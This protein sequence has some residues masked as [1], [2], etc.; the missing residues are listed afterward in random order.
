[1]VNDVTT[2][3]CFATHVALWKARFACVLARFP[4]IV[5]CVPLKRID[6]PTIAEALLSVFSRVGCPTGILSDRGTHFR[7]DLMKA[8]LRLLS[9]DHLTTSPYHA[10]TNGVVEWFNGTLKT[11]L[12][13]MASEKSKD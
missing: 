12:S 7:S 9:V 13:K 2:L 6:T 4:T 1:M 8:M 5:G 3:R 11:M 10:Q